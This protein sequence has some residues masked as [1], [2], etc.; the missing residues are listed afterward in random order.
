MMDSANGKVV[1]HVPIGDGVDANCFD[2]SSQLAFASCGDGTVTIAHEDSPEKL[3]VVQTLAT[4][5]GARTM[6]IDPATHKIYLGAAK[7]EPAKPGQRRPAIVP[8]SF[9]ILVYGTDKR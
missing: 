9:H 5:K 1:A 2:P 7:Y 6:I 4:K 8:G 3:T